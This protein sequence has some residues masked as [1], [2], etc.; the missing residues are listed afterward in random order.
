MNTI[1]AIGKKNTSPHL[2]RAVR[3]RRS[4][5]ATSAGPPENLIFQLKRSVNRQATTGIG[6]IAVPSDE[7]GAPDTHG[8]DSHYL[9]DAF[10]TY[11]PFRQREVCPKPIMKIDNVFCIRRRAICGCTARPISAAPPV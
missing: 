7:H 10:D 6:D 5:G 1:N 3:I 11:S 9:V 2:Q 4:L 8:P